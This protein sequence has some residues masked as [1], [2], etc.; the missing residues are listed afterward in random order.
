MPQFETFEYSE[1]GA[2][3]T[4]TPTTGITRIWVD[5]QLRLPVRAETRIDGTLHDL[6][7]FS[8]ARSRSTLEE[9]PAD[10]FA[11]APRADSA[12]G[13]AD[14]DAP[15]GPAPAA[16]AATRDQRIAEGQRFRRDFGLPHDYAIVASTVDAGGTPTSRI[17]HGVALTV[18]EEAAIAQRRQVADATSVVHDYIESDPSVQAVYGGAHVEYTGD[19]ALVIVS[20]ARVEE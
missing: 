1:P 4:G 9:H 7:L 16:P 13:A 8:Y 19:A 10:W 14:V 18:A 12:T 17:R 5:D 15:D 3:A 2:D 11:V 6:T 20:F